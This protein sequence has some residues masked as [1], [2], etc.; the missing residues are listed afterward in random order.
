MGAVRTSVRRL[1]SFFAFYSPALD[2]DHAE[3]IMDGSTVGLSRVGALSS[4]RWRWVLAAGAGVGIV[5]YLL[6]FPVI[7]GYVLTLYLLNRDIQSS[8]QFGYAYGTWGMPLTHMLL[9]GL[10]AS[11]VARKAETAAVTHGVLVALVSVVVGQLI[12]LYGAPPVDPAEVAKYLV[13]ALGGGLLGGL[14]GRTV[15]AGQEA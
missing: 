11:W 8:L 15:L 1:G 13:L 2:L 7:F 3:P 12:V 14:E 4:V 9:T 6:M 5:S 10:A